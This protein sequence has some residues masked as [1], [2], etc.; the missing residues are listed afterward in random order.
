MRRMIYVGLIILPVC[1][2]YYTS[3]LGKNSFFWLNYKQPM[4]ISQKTVVNDGNSHPH[5]QVFSSRDEQD[6]ECIRSGKCTY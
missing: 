5:L 2:L 6:P 4:T 3:N 1:F